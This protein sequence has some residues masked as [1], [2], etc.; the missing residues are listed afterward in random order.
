M[1][2]PPS[3]GNLVEARDLART[4]LMRE[5]MFGRVREV[6]AVDGVSLSIGRGKTFGLV[7]ESG[8]GKSTTGRMILGL[9]PPDFG[10]VAFDGAP[11]PA[12]GT[13]QWRS[14]R[15]RA[16]MIFQDPL[17]ALDRHL[18]I[19][20]QV[21]EPL[22]IHAIGDAPSR[23]ARAVALLAS[24]GLSQGQ[25]DRYPANCPE[26]SVSAPCWRGRLPR[27]RTSSSAT[28]PSARSTCRSRRRWSTS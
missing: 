26:A 5:G 17:G 21:R 16:Q 19:A 25:G 27:A 6:R 8:S 1:S 23:A 28:S 20:D 3:E 4:Y 24:V 11:M 7:G 15:Q 12:A 14:L 13:P 22:D 10:S 2:P 18:R 9:E